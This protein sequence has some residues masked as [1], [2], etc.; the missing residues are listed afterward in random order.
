MGSI[1]A[2]RGSAGGSN[3]IFEI[4]DE[5]LDSYGYRESQKEDMQNALDEAQ[6]AINEIMN[7]PWGAPSVDGVYDRLADWFP[8]SM[9]GDEAEKVIFADKEYI[10]TIDFRLHEDN[11]GKLVAT[12]EPSS[13]SI[14]EF[15]DKE[16]QDMGIDKQY[17]NERRK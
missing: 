11:N 2:N 14:D 5:R 7:D 4:R 6:R 17:L 9:D 12:L 10:T 8:Q 1:G 16:L 13:Y 15:S 3:T